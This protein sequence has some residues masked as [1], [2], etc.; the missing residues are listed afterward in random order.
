MDRNNSKVADL[1]DAYHPV[2]IHMLAHLAQ[3]MGSFDV[4]LSVCGEIAGDPALAAVLVG[5]GY[6]CLSM[7]ASSLLRV[8][9][10][11]RRVTLSDLEDLVESARQCQTSANCRELVLS[12]LSGLGIGEVVNQ[13]QVLRA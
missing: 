13:P 6:R 1:Y 4:E 11:L 5:M 10:V 12:R 9:W 3:E 2:V 7:S 8:K